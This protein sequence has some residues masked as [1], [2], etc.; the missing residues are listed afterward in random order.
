MYDRGH[1]G[2]DEASPSTMRSGPP[3]QSPQA[4]PSTP[5]PPAR[6][7]TTAQMVSIVGQRHTVCSTRGVFWRCA[8]CARWR[9]RF[10]DSIYAISM[11]EKGM[12]RQG[13]D[14]LRLGGLS[15]HLFTEVIK[16]PTLTRTR[17]IEFNQMNMRG[18][19]ESQCLPF[20]VQIILH[21]PSPKHQPTFC[22]C[23]S[24]L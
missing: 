9:A 12:A 22:D 20:P 6:L 5:P 7:R 11:R 17:M 15:I 19:K 16:G 3:P 21:S 24:V 2:S 18:D 10:R 1:G 13:G 4:L 23:G 8:H 14:I